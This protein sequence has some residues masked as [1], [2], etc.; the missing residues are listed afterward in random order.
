MIFRFVFVSLLFF[1]NLSAH[2]VYIECE[3]G[4]TAATTNVKTKLNAKFNEIGNKLDNIKDLYIQKEK[5]LK[6]NNVLYKKIFLLK[7]EYLL[8]LKE[9]N[10]ELNKQKEIK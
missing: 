7:R 3:S 10:F 4:V 6:E 8:N 9:I 2:C 1:A 5:A